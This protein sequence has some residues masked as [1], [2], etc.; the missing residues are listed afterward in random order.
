MT[1][2]LSR[3]L[4]GYGAGKV[5]QMISDQENAADKRVGLRAICQILEVV[6]LGHI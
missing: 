5:W 1:P 6:N 4:A 2:H 3:R